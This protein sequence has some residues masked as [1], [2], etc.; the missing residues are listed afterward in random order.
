MEKKLSK[1]DIKKLKKLNSTK[2]AN[3]KGGKEI[4]K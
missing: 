4:L 3:A 2:T 1:E